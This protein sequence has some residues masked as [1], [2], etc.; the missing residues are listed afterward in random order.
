MNR[1]TRLCEL[2][3]K[4]RQ[5]I[6]HYISNGM[7]AIQAVRATYPTSKQ[8]E[9]IRQQLM[10]SPKIQDVLSR[11]SEVIAQEASRVVYKLISKYER[12]IDEFIPEDRTITLRHHEVRVAIQAGAELSKILGTY[13]PTKQMS[14]TVDATMDR[15]EQARKVYEEY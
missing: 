7:N 10:E 12:V 1:N 9:T 2:S 5:F 14:L 15:L 3:I 11:N 13:A 6:M 4:Q 8:P